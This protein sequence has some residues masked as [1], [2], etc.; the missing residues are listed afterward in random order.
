MSIGWVGWLV[1]VGVCFVGGWGCVW[2]TQT[3]GGGVCYLTEGVTSSTNS[4]PGDGSPADVSS[5]RL[6]VG[7]EFVRRTARSVEKEEPQLEKTNG[8][9][10]EE[11]TR[12]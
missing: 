8:G 6:A 7:N 11:M 9:K 4:C 1:G 3:G 5:R 12:G 2:V 10:E